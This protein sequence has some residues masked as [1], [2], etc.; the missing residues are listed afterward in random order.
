MQPGIIAAGLVIGVLVGLTGMGGG[1]LTTPFLILFADVKPVLAVGT[2]LVYSAVTKWVGAGIHLRQR[3]VDLRLAGLLALGSVPAS[4][5]GVRVVAMVGD[6]A[7]RLVTHALGVMLAVV[8]VVLMGRRRLE[9]ALE[10]RRSRTVT[11]DGSPRVRRPVTIIAL[12]AVVGFLVG[13]TSVGSGTL[14]VAA[15]LILLPALPPS[16]VVG[17]DI[18]QA[19]VLTSAAGIAHWSLGNVDFG[20][21]GALLIGSIPGVIIGSRLSLRLPEQVLR[22]ALATMLLIVAIR[23]V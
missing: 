18:L 10:R 22:P 15:L 2:D 5:L 1:S 14:V 17:T 21:A 11:P 8:A 23:L 16:R 9:A 7:D 12:G 3:T 19:A 13:M 6:D 4:L 20:L